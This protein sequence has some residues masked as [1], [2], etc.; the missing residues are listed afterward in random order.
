MVTNSSFSTTGFALL[1]QGKDSDDNRDW[2]KADYI[3]TEEAI[4]LYFGKGYQLGKQVWVGDVETNIVEINYVKGESPSVEGYWVPLDTDP[5]IF[6]AV[7]KSLD[8]GEESPQPFIIPDSWFFQHDLC[9]AM[10][11]F[12]HSR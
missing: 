8:Q 9:N 3:H 5:A 7:W 4:A 6:T 10:A 1:I 12:L 2:Y 11:V